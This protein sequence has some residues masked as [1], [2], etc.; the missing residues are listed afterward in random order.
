[1]TR[2]FIMRHG[3]TIYNLTRRLQ[4]NTIHTPLTRLGCDQATRMGEALLEVLGPRPDA[5]I[6]VS[7]TGRA[8]QTLSLIA[9]VIGTDWF[10]AQQSADLREIDM[11]SW[12]LRSYDE[13]EAE[14]GPVRLPDHLLRPAPDGEDYPAITARLSR[15]LAGPGSAPGDH[16]VVMHGISSRVLRGIMAG[17]PVHPELGV[18]IAPSL[19]Q[20]SIA[21]VE[22]GG[23]AVLFG[24]TVGTQ[25]A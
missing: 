14:V 6:H 20:G 7:D 3:E 24:S 22:Q 25:H 4:S 10:A 9:E 15:W 2:H 5:Q 11:G 12:C 19:V 17:Y 23:E 8:L 21:L 13:L 16:V 18:P 1:M